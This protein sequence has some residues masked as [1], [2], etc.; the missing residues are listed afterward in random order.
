MLKSILTIAAL[1]ASLLGASVSASFADCATDMKTTQDTA[2]KVTDS[3]K[4]DA[5]M[6]EMAMAKDMMDKKDEAGC[7]MHTDAAMKA[8][9]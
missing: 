4:K 3:A 5:A 8:L 6:K 7:T 2:M 1:T 9:K